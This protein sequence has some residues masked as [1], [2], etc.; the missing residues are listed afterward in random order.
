M[1]QAVLDPWNRQN[2]V[3]ARVGP[4]RGSAETSNMKRRIKTFLA[5]GLLVLAMFGTAIAGPLEDATAG[6]QRGDYATALRICRPLAEQ[7]NAD[8]Q[9]NI[10]E[11]Y[12]KALRKLAARGDRGGPT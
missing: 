11:M 8:A 12:A 6:Y 10:R 1:K 5:G 3:G 4:R 9:F 2:G 7:G